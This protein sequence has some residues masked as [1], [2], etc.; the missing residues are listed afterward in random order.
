MTHFDDRPTGEMR[1]TD[2]LSSLL[3]RQRAAFVAR[4][5]PTLTERRGVLRR[6]RAAIREHAG[7]LAA[8]AQCDFSERAHAETMMVDVLPSVLHINHLLGGL[9]R[10]MKPSRRHT[11]WLFLTNR[12][13][14]M[15]QPKGVVGIVVP[16]NFPVYLA[17]GPLATALAAGNRCMVK[18]S[19]F[20]PHTSHALRAMLADVFEEDEVAVVE[21]DAAVARAF[22]ALPFDHIVFTGSP[23]VGRHVMRA[24]ADNLTPV[25]LGL[26]GKSPAV[27]SKSADLAVAARRIAHGKT[28]NAGQ[29]CVAPDYALVPEGEEEAFARR[30]MEAAARMH[31]AGSEDYAAVIHERAYERQQA[32]IDDARAHGASVFV[33]PM[34]SGGRRMPLHVVL[35]VTPAMRI[36]REEIFGPIL[37]VFTYRTF[38]AAIAQIQAGT[39]PLA[40]YYFGHDKAESD[41]LLKRTHAGGV[42]LNDWGWHV[43]N[44][45]MPFGGIGGSGMGNYHGEEGFRELSHGKSVFAEHRWFPIELFHPPYGSFVQRLAL[46]MFLG[47]VPAA[48]EPAPAEGGSR[49]R[50]SQP[51]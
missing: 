38:E 7:R 8:A 32:L 4:P 21:G 45:D 50:S 14:V 20:A 40:L 44:H 35:D 9:R 27:V 19:E 3:G 25:T 18:T 42:T 30:V 17:L 34:P 16:W 36:A 26:G 37:P 47:A 6:L 49:P 10:W 24:A 48:N 39:R 15:Y 43:L 23:E 22:C 5:Y 31:P 29:I 2:G 13:A 1:H 11:E 41:A 46:R 51:S 28:V 12:A 33:C